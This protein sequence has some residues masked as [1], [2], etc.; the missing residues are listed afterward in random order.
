MGPLVVVAAGATEAVSCAD[1]PTDGDLGVHDPP[2]HPPLPGR[3]CLLERFARVSTRR[4][5]RT[6]PRRGR[7]ARVRVWILEARKR[8]KHRFLLT[9]ASV[10]P[11]RVAFDPRPTLPRPRAPPTNPAEPGSSRA[12]SA[13][14]RTSPMTPSA[15]HGLYRSATRP[16]PRPLHVGAHG[17]SSTAVRAQGRSA[18][19]DVAMLDRSG[20]LKLTHYQRF[21]LV[22]PLAARLRK[23]F[24][25]IEPLAARLCKRFGLVEPLAARLCKR[26]GPVEP[27][28]ARPC[29]RFALAEPLAARLCK[30]FGLVEPLTARLCKRFAA[31][32]PLAARLCQRFAV[33][34]PLAAHLCKRFG[35]VE[36]L[37]AHLCE[38]AALLCKRFGRV[39]PLAAHLCKRFAFVEPLAAL[40][41]ERFAAF[42]PL[43]PPLA[44]KLPSRRHHRHDLAP[45]A[46]PRPGQRAVA[47]EVHR[48]RDEPLHVLLGLHGRL[49]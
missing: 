30:R 33:V 6:A 49:E 31:V 10:R 37:A 32:E 28:A 46:G 16:T 13:A 48:P 21:G 20:K 44:Q 35:P 26:F 24:G 47:E 5:L 11:R 12:G 34:E 14:R 38:S 9:L 42:Q 1:E 3:G 19:P 39:E 40:L 43:P 27:L 17:S 2:Q 18:T 15:P 7:E 4:W 23:R 29:E 36:P 8:N 25:L 45:I 41:C 22:E